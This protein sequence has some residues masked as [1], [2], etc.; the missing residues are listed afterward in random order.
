MTDEGL[1]FV[2]TN[3][4]VYRFDEDEPAKRECASAILE[5]AAAGDV[6]ISTQ[7][8]QEFYVVVTR[9]LARP[10]SSEDAE[11]IVRGFARLP[12]VQVDAAL[13][14]AAIGTSRRHKLSF[15]DA[16]IVQAALAGGCTRLLTEDLR[17]GTRYESLRVENPFAA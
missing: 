11:Q 2:D 7:V 13:V 15:W 10:V 9:K 5:S 12:I 1:A 4:L 14:L 16:L 8:L 3:V 6:V 17:H